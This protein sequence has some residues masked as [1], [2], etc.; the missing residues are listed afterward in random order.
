MGFGNTRVI[1]SS[2]GNLSGLVNYMRVH[3]ALYK[4]LCTS[5][6]R[7]RQVWRK[8]PLMCASNSA[9]V[10][11]FK[12]SPQRRLARCWLFRPCAPYR[13]QTDRTQDCVHTGDQP[14]L[15]DLPVICLELC[16][17]YRLRAQAM[18]LQRTGRSRTFH[19]RLPDVNCASLRLH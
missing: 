11:E 2:I 17:A 3:N 13:A 15:A 16:I 9:P 4:E 6:G 5:D 19:S 12:A 10:E 14:G 8:F 1:N 7:R 18:P